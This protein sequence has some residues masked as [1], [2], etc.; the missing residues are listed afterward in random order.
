MEKS[1]TCFWTAGLVFALFVADI[2]MAKVQMLSG[3][4]IPLHLGD[5]LQFL[6]LLLA[7]AFFVAGALIREGREDQLNEPIDTTQNN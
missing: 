2:L 4:T 6:V 5:T 3:I 7:V 1:R